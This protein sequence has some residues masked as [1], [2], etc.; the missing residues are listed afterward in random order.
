VPFLPGFLG[1]LPRFSEILPT[2]SGI[3]PRFSTNQLLGVRL[4]PLHPRL[5][6]RCILET[7]KTPAGNRNSS[8]K[9]AWRFNTKQSKWRFS[10]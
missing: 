1:I 4:H 7:R 3:L 9:Y 6:H 5:L 8:I 2:F 10:A